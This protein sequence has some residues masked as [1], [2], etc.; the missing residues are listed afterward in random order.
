MASTDK[1]ETLDPVFANA[2]NNKLTPEQ[3]IKDLKN[4][5]QATK[6]GMLTSRDKSGYLHA[7]AMTPASPQSETQLNLFFIANSASHKFDELDNDSHVNVSFYNEKTTDW[8]SFAGIAKISHDR[9]EIK[10]Y[11]SPMFAGYFGDLGDGVHKGDVND[12]RVTLIEVVPEEIE[13]WVSRHGVI[14]RTVE[15]AAA[16]VTGKGHAPGELRVIS[17]EEIQLTQGLH[18]K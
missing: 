11:W 7:R 9:E 2:V 4:V 13:Y 15:V 10:K 14:G 16:A 1:H 5:I 6:T 12:P 8:A 18:A 17:K 3:K